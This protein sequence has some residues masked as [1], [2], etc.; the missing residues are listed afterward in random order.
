MKTL[1]WLAAVVAGVLLACAED[2]RAQAIRIGSHM[3]LTGS[4]AKIGNEMAGGIRLA[5]EHFNADGGQLKA[6]LVLLDDESSPAKAVGAVERLIGREH[7][8]AISGGYGSNIIGPASE[9]AERARVPYITSGGLATGLT[10]RGF[11]YFFRVTN[12]EGYTVVA[13]MIADGFKGKSAA[14]LHD[15]GQGGTDVG[16]A[17]KAKLEARGVK[18]LLEASYP[19]DAADLK[20]LLERVALARPDIL[21]FIGYE[22]NYATALRNAQA[23]KPPVS[24]FVGLYSLVTPT[25]LRDLGPLTNWVYGTE[26]WS[27]GTAPASLREAEQR[28]VTDYRARFA[29]PPGYLSALGYM[30]TQVLLEALRKASASGGPSPDGVRQALLGAATDT[31]VSKVGFNE[32]GDNIVYSTIVSQVQDGKPTPVWPPSRARGPFVY[33]RVPW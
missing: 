31:I 12:Q 4:L 30:Q 10:R 9:V 2:A 25:M 24:A 33:P 26:P 28:F 20:P 7:V 17:V 21:V 16:R 22:N 11:R 19:T 6:E 15:S 13:D 18:L 1:G 32:A 3:P 29:Q 14:L 5:V 8:T 27:A 23:V